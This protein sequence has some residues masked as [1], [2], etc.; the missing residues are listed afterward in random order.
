MF[1]CTCIANELAASDDPRLDETYLRCIPE[2]AGL[3]P[4]LLVGVVHDHPASIARVVSVLE[5]FD[6]DTLAVE[7][8]PLAMPLF[9]QY[10]DDEHHPPRLGGEMS[11]AIQATDAA[12]IGVD[13]PTM[14]YL[15]RL[16]QTV[17]RERPPRSVLGRLVTDLG[18]M[19]KQALATRFASAIVRR[20]PFR[21]RV[22][23]PIEHGSSLLDPPR[24]QADHERSFLSQ[25]AA[26]FGAIH[27]P[28]ATSIIDDAREQ[29]MSALLDRARADGAVVAVLGMEHLDPVEAELHRLAGGRPESDTPA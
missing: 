12:S 8:P 4:V 25:R 26:L 19:A 21:L 1:D 3:K 23:D 5:T 6:P 7:L 16:L 13:A 28:E 14:T 20:T 10:A 9:R 22:Y 11:A 18:S 17:R 24:R 2:T 29:S 15:S 27:P